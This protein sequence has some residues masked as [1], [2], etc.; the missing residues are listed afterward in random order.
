MM[1]N[2]VGRFTAKAA[3]V[4]RP[5]PLSIML[6][7]NHKKFWG[8]LQGKQNFLWLG[9]SMMLNGVGRLTAAAFAVLVLHVYATGMIAGVLVGLLVA[10]GIAAW[11]TRSLWQP[12]PRPFDWRSLIRQVFP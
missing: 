6:Q 4:N 3:A 11:H 1:L 8:A 7:P 10:I 2:G 9:W 5:T 12:R